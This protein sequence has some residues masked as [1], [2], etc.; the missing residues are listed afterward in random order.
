VRDS[1]ASAML[2]E[3]R[4]QRQPQSKSKWA[5]G[6][7]TL[8]AVAAVAVLVGSRLAY[9]EWPWSA[10]PSSVHTC[11][12]DYLPAGA[13]QSR[14]TIRDVDTS[15]AFTKLGSVP[16]WLNH[17]SIWGFSNPTRG[18]SSRSTGCGGSIWIKTATDTFKPYVLSGGP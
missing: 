8:V 4:P 11:G 5:V 7:A 17:G 13:N 15:A 14:Q 9:H 1:V 18:T 16:G 2:R 6:I 10:A 12:R 3:A